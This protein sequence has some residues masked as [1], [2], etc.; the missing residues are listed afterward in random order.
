MV[1]LAQLALPELTV[2]RD[3]LVQLDQPDQ[4]DLV[5]DRLGQLV[6]RALMELLVQLE[7]QVRLEQLVLQEQLVQLV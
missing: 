6:L 3:Q 5:L 4:L 1:L 2:L 7:L